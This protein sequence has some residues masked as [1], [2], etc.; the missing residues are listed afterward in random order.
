MTIAR[1]E[2]RKLNLALG[3]TPPAKRTWGHGYRCTIWKMM[4]TSNC[5]TLKLSS[6]QHWCIKELNDTLWE[7]SSASARN[8][9]ALLQ[10]LYYYYYCNNKH[11]RATKLLTKKTAPVSLRQ[12]QDRQKCRV[13]DDWRCDPKGRVPHECDYPRK[14]WANQLQNPIRTSKKITS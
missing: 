14:S 13:N 7:L 8:L 10:R 1:S 9:L 12:I 3:A 6:E 4:R 2:E 5:F 11:R